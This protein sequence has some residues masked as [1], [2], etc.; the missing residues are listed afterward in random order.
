MLDTGRPIQPRK[1][2]V[3]VT[4]PI[5]TPNPDTSSPFLSQTP[6]ELQEEIIKQICFASLTV[7]GGIWD[8]PVTVVACRGC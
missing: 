6:L 1:L 5:V 8:L 3:N 2:Y 4:L 7:E